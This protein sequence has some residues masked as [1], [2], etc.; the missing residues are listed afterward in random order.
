MIQAHIEKLRQKPVHVRRN[1][2][3]GYTAVIMVVIIGIW[4]STFSI[5]S[6]DGSTA[7]NNDNSGIVDSDLNSA[8]AYGSVSKNK[9]GDNSDTVSAWKVL[10]D[11]IVSVWNTKDT[12]DS[13]DVASKG[14]TVTPGNNQ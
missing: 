13:E 10:K 14:L 1:Y 8:A 3:I 11:S 9:S 7:A 4:V 12:Y 6:L 2:A 5:K